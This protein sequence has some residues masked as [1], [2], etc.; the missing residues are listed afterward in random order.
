MRRAK[1]EIVFHANTKRRCGNMFLL[2]L[3]VTFSTLLYSIVVFEKKSKFQYTLNLSNKKAEKQP[4]C[5][6]KSKLNPDLVHNFCYIDPHDNS[7]IGE[8]FDCSSLSI[9]ENLGTFNFTQQFVDTTKSFRDPQDVVFLS[10]CSDDHVM[11]A[12]QTFATVQQFYPNQKHILY[13]IGISEGNRKMLL[14]KFKNVEIRQFKF[15][16][17]PQFVEQLLTY[18]WKPLIIAEVLREYPNIWW[19]DAHIIL[20]GGDFTNITYEERSIEL[21]NSD[22]IFFKQTGHSNFATLFPKVLEYIPSGS[23]SLLKSEEFGAQLGANIF[24]VSRTRQ[25]LDLFKWW[26]LCAL[27]ETCM[28]PPGAKV[29]CEFGPNRFDSFANCFRFDQSVINLLL[30]NQFQDYHKYTGS[31]GYQFERKSVSRFFDFNFFGY[32][33]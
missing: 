24:Y 9:L 4:D 13:D 14:N 5:Y 31:A 7:S 29:H 16:K 27:D 33:F 23:S 18:R 17:Y 15:S 2:I 30:L 3:A 26:L 22:I 12:E 25:T 19:M 8:K 11:D 6:C 28:N 21:V 32:F 1:H 10:A 20:I